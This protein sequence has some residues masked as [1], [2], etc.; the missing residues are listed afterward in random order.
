MGVGQGGAGAARGRTHGTPAGCPTII[1]RPGTPA[2]APPSRPD[3]D[4][5]KA[6]LII[7]HGSRKGEANQMLACVANLVQHLAGDGVIV[8]YAHME[9]A[10][11]SIAAGFGRCVARGASEVIAFPYMLSP[12]RHSTSDIP[13]LV[14]Q[15]AAAHPRVGFKVTTAFGVHEKLGELILLRAGVEP[16]ARL[17][18]GDAACCW[19]AAKSTTA[20]GEACR[21][22]TVDRASRAAPALDAAVAR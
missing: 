17:A 16:A 19:D 6:I 8:E 11:P 13:E 12:G 18:P 10:E 1:F 22:R 7:D 14:A 3:S 20:C 9:L 5:M 21:A 4:P 2:G 15:A